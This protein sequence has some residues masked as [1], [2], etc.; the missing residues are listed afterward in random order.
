MMMYLE[1]LARRLLL[2]TML[3]APV[4]GCQTLGS[5]HRPDAEPVR[6]DKPAAHLP[7]RNPDPFFRL[8]R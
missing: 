5:R 4:V 8:F 1:N 2:A 3:L 7:D 6:R